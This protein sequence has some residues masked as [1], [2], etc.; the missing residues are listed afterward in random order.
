VTPPGPPAVFQEFVSSGQ[1]DLIRSD[2]LRSALYEFNSYVSLVRAE[3][4]PSTAPISQASDALMR[5]Q[6]IKTTG[7]PT[8]D[9]DLLSTTQSVDRSILLS[10]PEIEHA[11]QKSYG[12]HDNLLLV[13]VKIRERMGRILALIEAEQERAK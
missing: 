9:F 13:L 5:A 11:L 4:G 3:F 6:T 1:T 10:D 2:A 12:T 8:K 7:I